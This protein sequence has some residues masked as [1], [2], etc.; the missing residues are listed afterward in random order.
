MLGHP[1]GAQLL[2][3]YGFPRLV[4]VPSRTGVQCAEKL[5]CL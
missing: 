4:D 3:S 5:A 1:R 2:L